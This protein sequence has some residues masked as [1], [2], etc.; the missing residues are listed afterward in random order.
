MK[1][2][3]EMANSLAQYWNAW[4]K[5]IPFIPPK[6][7]LKVMTTPTIAIPAQ[8]GQPRIVPITTPAPFIWGIV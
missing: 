6:A 8:Y 4:T 7:T 1:I 3:T 2:G 5:V